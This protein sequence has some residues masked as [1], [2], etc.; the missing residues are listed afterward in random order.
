MAANSTGLAHSA[1]VVWVGV[2]VLRRDGR[3]WGFGK[4]PALQEMMSRARQLFRE[5]Q[6]QWRRTKLVHSITG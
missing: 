6:D 3:L 4:G 5:G 2:P 1:Y